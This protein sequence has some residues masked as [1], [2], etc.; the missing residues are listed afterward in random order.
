M[1][2]EYMGLML[3]L[4]IIMT[5]TGHFMI[6]SPPKKINNIIGYRTKRSMKNIDTWSFAQRFSGK[7]MKNSGITMLISSI[8]LL[9]LVLNLEY[10]IALDICFIVLAAQLIVLLCIPLIVEKELKNTF[11]TDGVLK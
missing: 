2:F 8:I 1:M 7:Q 9:L 5:L 4:P 11:N 10:D 6:T 3:S